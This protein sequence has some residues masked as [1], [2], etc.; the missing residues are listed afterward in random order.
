MEQNEEQDI[1]EKM[2]V[3]EMDKVYYIL[4]FITTVMD[5]TYFESAKIIDDNLY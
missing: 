4:N 5:E 2:K 1:E 3:V